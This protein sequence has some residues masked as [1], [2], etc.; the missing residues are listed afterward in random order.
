MWCTILELGVAFKGNLKL[1]RV[2]KG[3]GIVEDGNVENVDE[4]HD[5]CG[6]E[7]KRKEQEKGTGANS[8]AKDK[9]ATRARRISILRFFSLMNLEFVPSEA[10]FY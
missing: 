2:R 7:K 1:Q 8:A 10:H 9:D 5:S 4:R 3:R 6:E